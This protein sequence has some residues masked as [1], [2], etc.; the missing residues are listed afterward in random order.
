MILHAATETSTAL[1]KRVFKSALCTM[2]SDVQLSHCDNEFN[3]H[4][5]IHCVSWFY[6][7]LFFFAPHIKTNANICHSGFITS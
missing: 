3:T 2:V 1:S 5:D 7:L 6:V 4:F